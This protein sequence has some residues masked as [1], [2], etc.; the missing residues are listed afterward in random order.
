MVV[1]DDDGEVLVVRGFRYRWW[2]ERYAAAIENVLRGAELDGD[3]EPGSVAV[4]VE[5]AGVKVLGRRI[6]NRRA[7]ARWRP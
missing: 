3:L 2:A 7:P 6:L 1:V 4:Y 5:E